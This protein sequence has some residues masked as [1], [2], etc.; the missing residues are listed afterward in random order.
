MEK[1]YR[2]TGMTCAACAAHVQRA[3]SKVPG[4]HSAEVNIAAGKL[5]HAEKSR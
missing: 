1:S 5:R 2:I 3:V 4:V